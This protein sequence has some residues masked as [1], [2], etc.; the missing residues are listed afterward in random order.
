MVA[1]KGHGNKIPKALKNG[2]W[3]DGKQ[4]PR[5]VLHYLYLPKSELSHLFSKVM[6][7][8]MQ[9]VQ[10]L[11]IA[12]EPRTDRDLYLVKVFIIFSLRLF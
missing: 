12:C 1:D 8:I 2:V 11:I 3:V 4:P 10:K 7:I 6:T 5:F 9:L